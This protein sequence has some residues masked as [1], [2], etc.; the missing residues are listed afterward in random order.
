[1]KANALADTLGVKTVAGGRIE[2]GR[3]LRIP[4]HPEA[5]AVGDNAQVPGRKGPLPQVAQVALQSG[6]H[7]AREIRR[8]RLGL[9][10]R[11]FHYFDKGTMATIGRRSAV[12]ELPGNIHLQGTLGWMAWLGLHLLYLV[13]FRNRVS[14]FLNWSW[15]YL[16]W[17]RGPRLILEQISEVGTD[18][19]GRSDEELLVG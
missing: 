5:F 4:G 18:S 11:P 9:P 1:V 14:V 7:A 19:S 3:D 12:A 15:N 16:T 8:A 17:D 2:V 10:S 6:R 13:G